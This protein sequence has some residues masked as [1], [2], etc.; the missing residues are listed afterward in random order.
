VYDGGYLIPDDIDNIEVCFSPGVGKIADFELDL[1]SRGIKCFLADYSVDSPPIQHKL[2]HFEKK[3]LGPTENSFCMTLESWVKRNAPN[4]SDF[5]LQMDVEGG[6]Y[7]V[8]H[9]SSPELLRK[10]RI[11]VIEF[12]GLDALCDKAGFEFINL[13]FVKLLNDFDVV[14]IHPCNWTERTIYRKYE[15]PHVLEFTFLRKD[16]ISHRVP[17]STFPHP[18]DRRTNPFRDDFPL[19]ECWFK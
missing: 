5:I 11:I 10:F 2:F 17:T 3:F 7:G 6:E 15:I 14:H 18:L 13:T 4:Q 1:A 16:R 19:P 9:A 12:H 8:L